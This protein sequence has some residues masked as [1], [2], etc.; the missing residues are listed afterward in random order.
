MV[1][2]HSCFKSIT[3]VCRSDLI[4]RISD[5]ISAKKE[6]SLSSLSGLITANPKSVLDFNRALM[7]KTGL[8]PVSENHLN[9]Q[10][11][12]NV[13]QK[14]GKGSQATF[15]QPARANLLTSPITPAP[16]H[17]S[18]VTCSHDLLFSLLLRDPSAVGPVRKDQTGAKP[19]FGSGDVAFR[20]DDASSL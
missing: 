20:S 15:L 7:C 3:S 6:T 5:W 14:E 10:Q 4:C 9:E 16:H 17:F 1:A 12:S 11:K 8:K 19:D 2:L 13:V 18:V